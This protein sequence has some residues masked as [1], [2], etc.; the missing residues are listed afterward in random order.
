MIRSFLLMALLATAAPAATWI[1]SQPRWPEVPGADGLG[2]VLDRPSSWEDGVGNPSRYQIATDQQRRAFK[3]LPYEAQSTGK[4]VFVIS[5]GEVRLPTAQEISSIGAWRRS[6]FDARDA[7]T[8]EAKEALR[9]IEFEGA[10][11]NLSE[12]RDEILTL[13]RAV[14]YLMRRVAG[15]EPAQ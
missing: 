2:S 8:V 15:L 1:D 11:T 5:T 6:A 4:A 3:A 7:E 13:R 14:K 9:D 12:A 10:I